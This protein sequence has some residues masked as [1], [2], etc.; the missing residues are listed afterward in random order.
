MENNRNRVAFIVGLFIIMVISILTFSK[1]I[2]LTK[3]QKF[4]IM[5]QLVSEDSNY[6]YQEYSESLNPNFFGDAYIVGANWNDDNS[7]N[8]LIRGFEIKQYVSYRDEVYSVSGGN[9]PIILATISFNQDGSAN[10]L[11]YKMCEDGTN[12]GKSVSE[13]FSEVSLR[14]QVKGFICN[15]YKISD[16]VENQVVEF[17]NQPISENNLMYDGNENKITIYHWDNNTNSSVIILEDSL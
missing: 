8:V 17:Y 16:N 13:M 1:D 7:A 2:T 14:L 3:S 9:T 10:L 6:Y 15:F 12:F 4:D 5:G 11:D